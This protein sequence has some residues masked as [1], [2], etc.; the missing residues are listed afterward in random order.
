MKKFLVFVILVLFTKSIYSQVITVED[1]LTHYPLA[2]VSIYCGRMHRIAY[3]DKNGR[4][5]MK[6]LK[7]SSGKL[8]FSLLGY[9]PKKL[10]LD[11]IKR[12]GYKVFMSPKVVELSQVVI[13]S[14]YEKSVKTT[15][16][17]LE[18]ISSPQIERHLNFSVTDLLAQLP[19]VEQLSTGPG[20][21]KPVIR[22]LYG[23]RILVLIAG[24]RFDA[25]QWQDEHGLGLSDIGISKIQLIKGPLSVLYGSDA[26]GGVINIV[27]EAPPMV[28]VKHYEQGFILHSNNLGLLGYAGFKANTGKR[29]YGAKI[30]AQ[31][32]ADYSDGSGKRVLNSRY[33]GYYLTSFYGFRH[34]NWISKN[35]YDFSVNR[36]GFILNGLMQMMKPDSRWSRGFSGPHHIVMLNNFV[37]ANKFQLA[38]SFLRFNWG[39]TSNLRAEDEGGGDYSLIMHL[40]TL[41]YSLSWEKHFPDNFQLILQNNFSVEN[42]TNYGKRK[43]IPNAWYSDNS[44]GFYGKHIG[45]IMTEE[46]GVGAGV[47]FIKTLLTPTVNSAEKEIKPFTQLRKFLNFMTGISFYPAKHFVVKIN[48]ST[49]IRVPDLAELS[50]DGLH[51]GTYTYEIGNPD[52]KNERDVGFETQLNY[53]NSLF[54]L[55]LSGYY[56]FFPDYIY[57]QPTNEQWYGFAVYRYMQKQAR[58]Y[59][60]ESELEFYPLKTRTLELDLQYQTLVGELGKTDYLPFMPADRLIPKIHLRLINNKKENLGF[61]LEYEMVSAQKKVNHSEKPTPGYNLLNAQISFSYRIRHYD[62]NV[63]L[64][65]NNLTNTL[66]YDNLSRL[67]FYGIYNMG[68]DIAFGLKIS[69]DK[70]S[71]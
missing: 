34:K 54:G 33:D 57:L 70:T 67:K 38:N 12:E 14:N 21:S 7:C 4:I 40:I 51:E 27:P 3:T 39:M 8:E 49:G 36:Y 53:F 6:L 37:S 16:V 11:Q 20:I 66:Y 50:S 43:I 35:F 30:A 64:R 28:G 63:F 23:Y 62:L 10:T 69:F 42:N 71:F 26:L 58:I 44:L 46:M 32:F 56:T 61:M 17:E 59:G 65:G 5:S 45:R 2:W 41:Q 31:S 68:R 52:L 19:G 25:Q 60:Q 15:S 55:R 9:K 22:G 13:S 18:D 48:C 24:L 29:W 1:S 47:R